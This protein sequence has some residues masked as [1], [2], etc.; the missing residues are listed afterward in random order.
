MHQT[1]HE[2]LRAGSLQDEG[3]L[4]HHRTLKKIQGTRCRCFKVAD[5][6]CFPELIL[7]LEDLFHPDLKFSL[8]PKPLPPISQGTSQ[9]I[10]RLWTQQAV[11]SL[12]HLLRQ[13]VH[14]LLVAALGSIVKLNQSQSLQ[15]SQ[16]TDRG[17]SGTATSQAALNTCNRHKAPSSGDQGLEA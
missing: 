13:Q 14:V 2:S 17:Q 16:G 10:K 6:C 9:C 3:H 12:T 7:S 15:R 5:C 4:A 11:S 8:H 1:A